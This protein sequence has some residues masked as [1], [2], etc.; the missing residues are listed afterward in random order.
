MSGLAPAH[1]L[2]TVSAVRFTPYVPRV[3]LRQLAEN[4]SAR[5]QQ[6]EGTLVFADVSGFTRLSERLARKGREGA[7]QLSDTI[8]D[9]FSALLEVA[10]DNGGSLIKFGGDAVL[11]LFEGDGHALRGC[12]SAAGMRR[13]LR[14][15][16]RIR[17]DGGGVRLSMSV[18]VHSGLFHLFL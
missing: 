6:V 7:E 10:Y 3:L 13:L 14:S 15:V 5:V 1:P 12:H 16:G 9:C 17:L 11:L 2:A 4:P 18:G 8:S